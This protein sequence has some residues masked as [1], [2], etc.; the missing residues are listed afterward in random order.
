MIGRYW[1]YGTFKGYNPTALDRNQLIEYLRTQNDWSRER[2]KQ[3]LNIHTKM[4]RAYLKGE[5]VFR[6]QGTLYNVDTDIQRSRMAADKLFPIVNVNQE[7][8]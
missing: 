7:E 4:F 6:Y 3:E 8:E 2:A 5:R 1:P